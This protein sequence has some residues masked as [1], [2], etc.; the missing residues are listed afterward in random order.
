MKRICL[1][2]GYHPHGEVAEYAVY[3][4]KAMSALADVYYMADCKMSPGELEKLAPYV[5]GAWGERHSKYDFGSWQEIVRK[6][7]WEKLAEYDECIFCNDS[8]FAPLFP[9]E[10]VF[11]QAEK[12][13]SLDAWGL[14]AFE[15]DYFGS[16]FF[17]LKRRA[18]LSD[19]FKT[20]LMSVEKQPDVGDVIRKYEKNLPAVLRRGGFSYRVFT[21]APQSVFNDWKD[22]VRRGFPVL[23]IQIFTRKRLY[24]DRQWLP[25]WRAFV[26]AH[27]GYPVDLIEKHLRRIGV[28]PDGFDSFGFRLKSLWWA[29]RRWRRKGFR[30]HFC[31]GNN[32]VVLF[33]VTLVNNTAEASSHPVQPFKK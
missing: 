2:A 32:I 12:D 28:D 13:A 7:G 11:A 14:N 21:A 4:I 19:A 5:K 22:Y 15:N 33:G 26:R 24:A 30:V 20:F 10:P 27:S 3:Y 6:I 17:V 16:F 18:V 9:L 25:G 31:R 29:F 23:K 8:G 1:F